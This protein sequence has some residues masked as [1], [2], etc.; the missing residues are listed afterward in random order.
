MEEEREEQEKEETAVARP[1]ASGVPG[2]RWPPARG[3]RPLL[4]LATQGTL[5]RSRAMLV[6]EVPRVA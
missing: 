6:L 4:D 5:V 2:A 3:A 1:A